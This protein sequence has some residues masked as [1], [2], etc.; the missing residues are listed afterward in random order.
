[1]DGNIHH[2]PIH[3]ELGELGDPQ[4]IIHEP[5]NVFPMKPYG[6]KN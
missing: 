1:M 2:W 6:I 5:G 4:L 3:L